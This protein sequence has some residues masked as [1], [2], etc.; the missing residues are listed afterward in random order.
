MAVPFHGKPGLSIVT[1]KDAQE[2]GP[3]KGAHGQPPVVILG[4][5]LTGISTA[6]HL[7]APWVLFE[8][9]DRLGGHART[10]ERDG[11]K[12]DKTGH[13][14]H[15]R[16]AGVKRLVEEILP[17]EM[18]PIARRARIFSHG[19]LTRFPFQA[20]LHGLPPEVVKECLLG[21]IEAKVKAA[22]GTDTSDPKN[23][24]DYCL[25]HFGA[26]ISKHFMIPYNEKLW[27][28]SPSEITAAWCSRFV[29]LPNLEQI[30]AGAVGAGPPEMGYNVSFLYPKSG[31]IEVFARALATRMRTQ[32]GKVNLGTSP[33]T[34]DWQRR[35][36]VAG[37][38]RVPYR[39]LVATIPL[40]ELLRRRCAT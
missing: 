28:V 6:V 31:G 21:V 37:G 3:K 17:G 34:I 39:A 25:R 40:P 13:W 12:F 10:D 27:G 16:D 24:E 22:A 30:V 23:F 32:H 15:L 26:G 18:V 7:D 35:E 8:R 20:N 5:G 4:G 11:Y 19:G 9:D 2:G 33:D 36:V 1:V 29:P 38:E 14:L